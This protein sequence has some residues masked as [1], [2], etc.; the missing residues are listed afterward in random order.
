MF[1]TRVRNSIGQIGLAL[2][3]PE[4]FAVAWHQRTAHYD[5]SVFAALGCTA[6]LGTATYGLIMGMPQGASEMARD[7]GR[8]TLAA[9]IAWSLPLPAL[10]IL[11]SL[12]GSRLK[13]STTLLAA[14]VTT[15]WGGLAMMAGI[16]IAW[17]FTFAI[18]HPAVVL[19]VHLAVFSAV[20]VAMIDVFSR[21]MA[22]LEPRR[23]KAPA[24]W[25]LLVGILGGEL[26]YA[27]GLFNLGFLF[28][29]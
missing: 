8:F 16:P 28:R 20:G 3:E 2:R 9:G 18:P 10:Y 11:N 13:P 25:L 27:L 6:I 12:S 19:A 4:S 24:W 21:T 1:R 14:L 29:P 7:A 23:G 5:W 22:R 15:S 26:F 17:F